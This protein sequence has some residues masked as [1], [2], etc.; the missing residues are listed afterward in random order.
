MS[1]EPRSQKNSEAPEER[2]ISP[3]V[4]VTLRSSGAQEHFRNLCIR[5][6]AA[7]RPGHD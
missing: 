1:I 2:N 3:L 5:H 7:L 4:R 6:L